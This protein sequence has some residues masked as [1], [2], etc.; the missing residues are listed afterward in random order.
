[1]ISFAERPDMAVR[2][3]GGV[4]P[5]EL[6]LAVEARDCD[7]FLA[8]EPVAQC[9]DP[10]GIG[11]A[12]P[13]CQAFLVL[14]EVAHMLIEPAPCLLHPAIGDQDAGGFIAYVSGTGR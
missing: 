14:A 3:R 8:K 13:C 2:Q 5:A 4:R 12:V 11:V 6:L 9:N 7:D 1:M 10:T